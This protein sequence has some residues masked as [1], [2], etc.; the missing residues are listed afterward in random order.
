V[1]KRRRAVFIDVD[2]PFEWVLK[3]MDYFREH[4]EWLKKH[5][6]DMPNVVGIEVERST[7]GYAHIIVHLDRE[8]ADGDENH[9]ALAM[10][11]SFALFVFCKQREEAIGITDKV[12]FFPGDKVRERVKG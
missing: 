7:N 2:A 3:H 11:S 10:G 9:L 6:N 4:L 5:M 12:L 1:A 8:I